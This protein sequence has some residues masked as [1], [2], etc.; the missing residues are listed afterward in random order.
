MQTKILF[1]GAL[2]LGALSSGCAHYAFASKPVGMASLVASTQMNE[3]V[4]PNKLGAKH[5]ESC[6]KSVLGIV[7]WGDASAATAAK[8]GGISMVSSV[9]NSYLNVL[10][11]FA[12][13]CAAVSGD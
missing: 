12:K 4:T 13:Y 2:L 9:D 10:G 7:T 8:N 1:G 6:A 5:G 11:V 3:A